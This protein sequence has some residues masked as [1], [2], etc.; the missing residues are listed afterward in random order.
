[1]SLWHLAKDWLKPV[2]IDLLSSDIVFMKQ[3]FEHK[4]KKGCNTISIVSYVSW[5]YMKVI[6]NNG[7]TRLSGMETDHEKSALL[8]L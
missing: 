3:D 6:I 1:M 2:V 8:H 7:I 5:F 4:F